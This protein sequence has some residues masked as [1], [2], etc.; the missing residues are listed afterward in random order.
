LKG[1][2]LKILEDFITVYGLA[3]MKEEDGEWDGYFEFKKQLE[4]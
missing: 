4:G 3:S 2:W 1:P